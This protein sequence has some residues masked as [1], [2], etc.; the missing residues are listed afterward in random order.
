[1]LT[2]LGDIAEKEKQTAALPVADEVIAGEPGPIDPNEPAYLQSLRREL[3]LRHYAYSTEIAYASWVKQF[4][5]WFGKQG[6]NAPIEAATE[7]EIKEYLSHLAVVGN[8]A[9][10]T[11]NQALSAL[12]FLYQQVLGK[13]LEFIDATRAKRNKHLPV[14]LTRRELNCI[15]SKLAGRNLLIARLLYG[16]GLRHNECLRLRIKDIGLEQS[17]LTIRDTKGREDRVTV[18]PSLVH[19]DLRAQI[20]FVRQL[21]QDDLDAGMGR[22]SLPYALERKYPDA[23]LEFGWQYLFPASK[24]SRNPQTGAIRRHHLHTSVFASALKRALHHSEI[25]KTVKPHTL[26]HSFA[27]HLLQS[28]TDIRTIQELLGHKDVSTTMIYTHVL[29]RPGVSVMSPLDG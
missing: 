2:T 26:R 7:N 6:S 24:I 20:E 29:N 21:H 11:Q 16:S 15:L 23:N 25:D 27:T 13:E 14:V 8:V 4:G 28:G 10:S 19:D 18:L 12:L 3:R 17:Q 1:M 5:I 9:A 22:V